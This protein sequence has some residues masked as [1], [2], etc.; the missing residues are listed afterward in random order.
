MV[1]QRQGTQRGRPFKYVISTPDRHGNVRRYYR[2]PGGGWTRLREK[3]GTAAF[4]AE[5]GRAVRSEATPTPT[6]RRIA[7][8]GS[9]RWLCEQ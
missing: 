4:D 7:R 9:L 5:Y 2:P 3:P 8:Q 1:K 6:A